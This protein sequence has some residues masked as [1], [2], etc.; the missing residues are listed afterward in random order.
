VVHCSLLKN[1]YLL[2]PL[3]VGVYM[4]VWI[5]EE[6]RDCYVP[7]DWLYSSCELLDVDAGNQH[8]P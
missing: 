7:C 4:S 5:P 6:P 8:S 1:Y 3:C 2:I